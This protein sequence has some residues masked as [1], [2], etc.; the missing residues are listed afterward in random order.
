[1]TVGT[2]YKRP[3]FFSYFNVL[4]HELTSPCS[5]DGPWC[6]T[7]GGGLRAEGR[8]RIVRL[9]LKI[10]QKP[11]DINQTSNLT[12]TPHSNLKFLLLN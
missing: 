2:E 1:V 12:L 6:R 7:K 8:L 11:N 10:G 9:R 4:H 3:N 5:D